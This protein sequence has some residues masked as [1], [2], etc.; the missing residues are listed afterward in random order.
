[1][2]K[3]GRSDPC[4]C[5]SGKKYKKCCLPQSEPPAGMENSVRGRLVEKLLRFCKKHFADKLDQAD[6]EFW[7]DFGPDEKLPDPHRRMGN[8]N[9]W[10]WVIFDWR[11]DVDD[12]RTVIEHFIKSAKDLSRL[13]LE[14]LE[15]MNGSV[16]SLYEVQDFQRGKGVTLKDLLLGRVYKVKEKSASES[17]NKWEILAARL[18]YLDGAHSI[19]GSVY[20]YSLNR[21]ERILKEIEEEH[22]LYKLDWPKA[23]TRDFLKNNSAIFNHLWM[24]PFETPFT[25]KLMTTSGE[26][27]IFCKALYEISDKEAVIKALERHPDIDPSGDNSFIWLGYGDEMGDT[28]IFGNIELAKNRL[29]LECKSRER[30]EKG[31]ALIGELASGNA[32]HKADSFEDVYQLLESIKG[33]AAPMSDPSEGI[34]IEVQQKLY[35]KFMRSHYE[36]TL[37]E[38]IP[39]LSGKAP[40]DAVKTKPGR[41]KV[42]EWLKLLENGEEQKKHDDQPY[43]DLTWM[44]DRLGLDRAKAES[45]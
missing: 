35:E 11:P 23:S 28:V 6:F 15:K 8:I 38:K 9:F 22:K 21:K 3:T 36:K 32:R 43:I 30:L 25:P 27:F 7:D 45:R 19:N 26:E 41:K 24:E 42:V 44:W 29:T 13:D 12:E 16:I 20:P 4:P 31:K 33:E 17:L 39:M 40:V 2:V 5:G 1:M 10:E 18:I 14:V 34:P 37:T